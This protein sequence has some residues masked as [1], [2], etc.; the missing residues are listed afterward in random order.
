MGLEPG[1][2]GRVPSESMRASTLVGAAP[3]AAHA[4]STTAP[5]AVNV[6]ECR[7]PPPPPL[8]PGHP[9]EAAF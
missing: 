6:F 8:D 4:Q 3:A 2:V 5:A 9:S 7:R 1:G